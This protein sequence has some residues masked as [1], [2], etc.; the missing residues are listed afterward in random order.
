[1][2]VLT[3]GTR[4]VPARQQTL[5][6]TIAWS[7]HLLDAQEQ[8]LFRRLSVFAGGCTLEAIEA[9][10]TTL[11]DE[12]EPVLD[13]VASLIDKSLLQQTEQ[14]G[15]EPRLVMLETVR[16][17]GLERLAASGEREASWQAHAEYYLAL[18][19]K[20]EPELG[21]PQQVAWLERL[22]REHDNVRAAMQW[23]LER[24]EIWHH[25]EM[26]LRL[27]AALWRFWRMRCQ[28]CEGQDFLK[29]AL[30][31]SEGANPS[32]RAKAL[33][34]AADLALEEHG[35]DQAERLCRES[36][37]LYR[38]LGDKQGIAASLSLLGWVEQRRFHREVAYALQAEGLTLSKELG[39]KRGIAEALR[40]L[41]SLAFSQ[42]AYE[43][44]YALKEESLALFRELGDTWNIAYL[45]AQVANVASYQGK[46]AKAYPLAEESVALFRELGDKRGIADGLK[47]LGG[48]LLNQGEYARAGSF[49]EE[50]LALYREL[51]L[52]SEIASPLYSLGRVA[53][54]QGD[55]TRAQALHREGLTLSL[56]VDA[57]WLIALGLEELGAVVA[58][59]GQPVWAVRLVG[60]AAALRKAIGS[61]PLPA[62]RSNY[63]RGIA[64]ART[65][66]GEK[67][68]A[69]ALA[70][71]QT[72]TPQQALAAQEPATILTSTSAALS[73][74]PAK[75]TAPYP[76]GLTVREV[77]VLR[78]VAQGLTDA[79]VAEQLII[80][81]R[82]VNTHLTTIYGKIVVSSRSAATRYA[83]EHH[84]V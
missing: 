40:G 21:G 55:Y 76:D 53:F 80:S 70:E 11:G 81:P 67:A 39:D 68:F 62:E 64:Y 4:D 58:L 54:G 73:N 77:E 69:A 60:A 72:M 47:N 38:E 66:L 52:K 50:G 51:G 57:K 56:E 82:T 48:V 29:R 42:G 84:L 44:A 41:S 16:E 10:C 3:S 18:A 15:E 9:I 8:R 20:A 26:A 2:A 46:Y 27:G 37:A 23:T 79:Q 83:I 17:Y 74:S 28:F 63:E 5:R 6:N 1:L 13:A 24:W 12:A 49:L 61:I 75:S 65:Q 22:E 43:R 19:E 71:G 33:N 36:L 34:V 45:L 30:A 31:G 25:M 32:V 59:Q 14:E 78:L 35:T 7:Y